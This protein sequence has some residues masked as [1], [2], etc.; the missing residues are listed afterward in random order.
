MDVGRLVP[1]ISSIDDTTFPHVL[2]KQ[3]KETIGDLVYVIKLSN[4]HFGMNEVR[5]RLR[6]LELQKIINQSVINPRIDMEALKI[7]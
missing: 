1:V 4:N 2:T 5:Y 7:K 6:I 3:T